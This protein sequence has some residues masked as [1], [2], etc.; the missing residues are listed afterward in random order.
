MGAYYL[1]VL[2]LN[3]LRLSLGCA[4]GKNPKPATSGKQPS[5]TFAARIVSPLTNCKHMGI[6]IKSRAWAQKAT[7][8][9]LWFRM[10]E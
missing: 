4:E 10:Y 2:L 7:D 5:I 1:A 8:L 3:M 6:F 9:L